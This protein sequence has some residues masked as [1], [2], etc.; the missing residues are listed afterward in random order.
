MKNIYVDIS[1]EDC[2]N[3]TVE[4]ILS[5]IDNLKTMEEIE[6][7][8]ANLPENKKKPLP[9]TRI[10]KLGSIN[11]AKLTEEQI[12]VATDKGWSVA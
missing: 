12:K 1:V 10:L 9:L 6:E 11:L 7:W 8:N 5:I 2:P 4:S 3:I